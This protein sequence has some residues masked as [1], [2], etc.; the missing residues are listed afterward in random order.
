MLN[1][2]SPFLENI[3]SNSFGSY[4]PTAHL[5]RPSSLTLSS[6]AMEG[7]SMMLAYHCSEGGSTV[8]VTVRSPTASSTVLPVTMPSVTITEL[9]TASITRATNSQLL[10]IENVP[11]LTIVELPSGSNSEVIVASTPVSEV[12][13]TATV[14]ATVLPRTRKPRVQKLLPQVATIPKSVAAVAHA[15]R[16]GTTSNKRGRSD[17]EQLELQELQLP[18]IK[19]RRGR[20]RKM[21]K[22][23]QYALSQKP[24]AK[25]KKR[26]QAISK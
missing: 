10:A 25:K 1:D 21:R 20:P 14:A 11:P 3:G 7:A 18:Q 26:E 2:L 22:L 4:D 17:D 8:T 15:P 19:K 16:N 6:P 12:P 13:P 5:R 24:F 23:L 9:P